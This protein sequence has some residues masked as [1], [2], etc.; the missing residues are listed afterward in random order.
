MWAGWLI[1]AIAL[2]A[3]LF[4]LTFLI[5][6][7][8]ESRPSVCYWIVPVLREPEKGQHLSVL[9]GI[10]FDDDCFATRGDSGDCRLELMENEHHAEEKCTSGL[11][12]RA[13]DPVPDNVVWRPIQSSRGNVVRGRWL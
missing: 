12:D 9:R 4:M 6:L 10:Y 1:A 11:I 13:V 8:R 3:T 2:A 7:L 5:A